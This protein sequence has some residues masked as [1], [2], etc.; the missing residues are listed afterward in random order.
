MSDE[1][2]ADEAAGAG[3]DNETRVA[4]ERRLDEAPAVLVIEAHAASHEPAN[5]LPTFACGAAA[6]MDDAKRGKPGGL[7]DLVQA[8]AP[9][10][11]FEVEE[12]FRIE[13]AGRV[14]RLAADEHA[15]AGHHR[16]SHDGR[17]ARRID[18]VAKIVPVEPAR[19]QPPHK[20]RRKAAKEEIEHGWIALAKIV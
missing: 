17:I 16:Q 20:P 2:T 9:I 7:S 3:H 6:V 13:T 12:E 5:V 8:H 18:G 1:R 11:V 10:E 15:A 19:E 14:D 4:H